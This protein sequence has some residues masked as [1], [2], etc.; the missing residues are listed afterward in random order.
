MIKILLRQISI[1]LSLFYEKKNKINK[2]K[3]FL[4]E[5][6]I[7]KKQKNYILRTQDYLFTKNFLM[8]Y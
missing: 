7:K 1:Y 2:K 4:L 8:K 3:S 6:Y 5:K